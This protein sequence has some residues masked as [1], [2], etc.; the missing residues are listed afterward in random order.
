MPDSTSQAI[1][2]SLQQTI[3]DVPK[4]SDAE[5]VFVV[6]WLAR[7]NAI[8]PAWWSASRDQWL[9]QFWKQGDHLSGAVYTFT[10]KMT[11][12]PVKVIPRDLGDREAVKQ[13]AILT[14]IVNDAPGF[15]AGWVEE[16]GRFVED[17][18]TQDNGAFMEVIGF[19]PKNGPIV[20]NPVGL[21]HL[22]S[23]RCM[24]TGNATYP[25]IYTDYDGQRYKLHYTRVIMASQMPSPR[26]EMFKVGFCAVSR[27]L[28]ISQNLID[29]VVY[30]QEK[31]GSRPHRQIVVTKGGLDPRD[32][33]TAFEIAE[34]RMD[35]T[36]LTRY[37]KVV[38]AGQQT[39]P[40]ADLALYE[41]S[42]MPDGFDEQTSVTMGMATIALAFGMDARELFPALTAGATRA[43]ALLQ[44]LKQRGKGPGQV[45]QL[46]ERQMNFKFCPA[47]MRFITDF[48]DDA[49]DRQE[50]E[51]RKVRADRRVQ[52]TATNAVQQRQI[53][54]Q[55]VIDG[56]ITQ[57]QFDAM[58]L[59][60]GRLPN[61][62][63]SISL[64]FSK[65]GDYSQYL[66]FPGVENPLDT[67]RN[68]PIEMSSM[69][70]DN[71][72]K[73][74]EALANSKSENERIFADQ[75]LS[76][77][78]QL[79]VMYTPVADALEESM[80]MEEQAAQSGEG[81][82]GMPGRPPK[83]GFKRVPGHNYVDPRNRKVN[84]T[85]LTTSS[86]LNTDATDDS[87]Q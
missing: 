56:D 66:A 53:R 20:G 81:S 37:S 52:D 54:E 73:V 30:K 21:A 10:S 22:D 85:N 83:P 77:L 55:M 39:L 19:G 76:A 57:Q 65:N 12:I 79:E 84:L 74:Y 58:E 15:G 43:D 2:Q 38:V 67:R 9:R 72:A 24:R 23:G 16:Y 42:G 36:G 7:N 61:G 47:T 35:A 60:D 59:E 11:A 8:A 28:G 51:I 75:A 45:L 86:D 31:L 49:Q 40:E 34:N 50:A 26:L 63:P 33:Q 17:L 87:G 6:N 78:K 48:Q 71:E 80:L 70:L 4:N 44:H 69:I 46:T 14:D 18:V 1:E 32:I 41:L 3:Q 82:Q 25:I 27:C 68:D 5:N 29:I 62:Q 64:V 13:A